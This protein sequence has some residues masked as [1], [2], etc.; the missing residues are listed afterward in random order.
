[1]KNMDPIKMELI[2]NAILKTNGK[3][4][5]ALAPVIMSLI[6]GANRQGIRFSKEEISLILD[7]MK[8]GKAPEEQVRI[9]QMVQMVQTIMGNKGRK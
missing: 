7:L 2:R 8:E 4:G 3:T 9:D 5:Q 6:T 1:M